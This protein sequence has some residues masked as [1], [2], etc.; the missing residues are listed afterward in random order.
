MVLTISELL[1]VI[2]DNEKWIPIESGHNI[3]YIERIGEEIRI[4][5]IDRK[6]PMIVRDDVKF[7]KVEE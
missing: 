4:E 5:A 7:R 2:K 1:R 6:F 3:K